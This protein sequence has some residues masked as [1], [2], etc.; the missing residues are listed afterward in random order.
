MIGGMQTLDHT[1][2]RRETCSG[3][4]NSMRAAGRDAA[5]YVSADHQVCATTGHSQDG[6]ATSLASTQEPTKRQDRLC[7]CLQYRSA[8]EAERRLSS[9]RVCAPASAGYAP[10]AP[11]AH[12]FPWAKRGRR[13]SD[14]RKFLPCRKKESLE[15]QA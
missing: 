10:A 12:T 11:S 7:L 5:S 1:R 14:V 4:Q 2:G 9:V 6:C 15:F 8:A 3:R 13:G